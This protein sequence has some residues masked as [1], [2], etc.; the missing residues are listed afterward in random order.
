MSISHVASLKVRYLDRLGPEVSPGR[1]SRLSALAIDPK[2]GR[3]F[4]SDRHYNRVYICSLDGIVLGKFGS[5][6]SNDEQFHYGSL[7][8]DPTNG[9]I[10]VS[11][12]GH[13]QILIFSPDGSF[14]YTFGSAGSADGQFYWPHALAIDPQAQT[15]FV[16]DRHCYIQS[17]NTDGSFR[18]RIG[19]PS[20]CSFITGNSSN[21]D[22]FHLRRSLAI[23]LEN[24]NLII[25]DFDLDEIQIFKTDGTFV[26]KF[27][28]S[29]PDDDQIIGVFELA[30]NPISKK[31]FLSYAHRRMEPRIQIFNTDGVFLGKITLCAS[32]LAVNSEN[33][34]LYVTESSRQIQIF[35]K[36]GVFIRTFKLRAAA[37]Y[38]SCPTGMAIEPESGNIFVADFEDDCIRILKPDGSALGKFGLE[39]SDGQFKG[40]A[41][42]TIDSKSGNLFVVDTKHHQIQIFTM[43]GNYLRQFGSEGSGDCQFLCPADLEVDSKGYIFVSDSDNHCLQIIAPD[44]AFVGRIGSRGQGDGQFDSPLGLAIDPIS[45]NLFV[46]DSRNHRV[47]I[48]DSERTFVSKFG[49]KGVDNGQFNQPTGLVFDPKSRK[50]FVAD[51]LNCR[52]QIFSPDGT[53]CGKFSSEVQRDLPVF[54]A[55]DPQRRKLFAADMEHNQISVF[56][57]EFPGT[58]DPRMIDVFNRYGITSDLQD[59]MFDEMNLSVDL[60]PHLAVDSFVRLGFSSSDAIKLLVDLLTFQY[61]SAPNNRVFIECASNPQL[62]IAHSIPHAQRFRY[63]D[64]GYHHTCLTRTAC[65]HLSSSVT[66]CNFKLCRHHLYRCDLPDC[67]RCILPVNLRSE[68]LILLPSPE[69]QSMD[70]FLSSENVGLVVQ[71]TLIPDTLKLSS[72]FGGCQFHHSVSFLSVYLTDGFPSTVQL[73]T[74]IVRLQSIKDSGRNT[75]LLDDVDHGRLSVILLYCWFGCAYNI[76]PLDI[77]IL[78]RS[79]SNSFSHQLTDFDLSCVKSFLEENQYLISPTGI[80]KL[81]RNSSSA[82]LLAEQNADICLQLAIYHHRLK[83]LPDSEMEFIRNQYHLRVDAWMSVQVIVE[84]IF[85]QVQLTKNQQK[86]DETYA[87]HQCQ[88]LQIALLKP[89]LIPSHAAKLHLLQFSDH[90]L[91]DPISKLDV[92]KLLFVYFALLTSCHDCAKPEIWAAMHQQ[93]VRLLKPFGS[94]GDVDTS[95]SI[96][97]FVP[98]YFGTCDIRDRRGIIVERFARSFDTRNPLPVIVKE[99]L[100]GRAQSLYY[101][102][103]WINEIELNL[104]VACGY[105]PHIARFLGFDLIPPYNGY[106]SAQQAPWK[107]RLRFE[108]AKGG[109]LENWIGK[110][111]NWISQS[112]Q[113]AQSSSVEIAPISPLS[114]RV[115]LLKDIAHGLKVLH[116]LGVVHRDVKDAN[117]LLTD[118]EPPRAKLCDF[119]LSRELQFTLGNPTLKIGPYGLIAP[120]LYDGQPERSHLSKI[121]VWNFGQLAANLCSLGVSSVVPASRCNQFNSRL[122]IEPDHAYDHQITYSDGEVILSLK[123]ETDFRL[124]ITESVKRNPVVRPTMDQVHQ[125]LGAMFSDIFHHFE[126]I[127]II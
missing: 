22:H 7:A 80:R 121:D 92:A 115:R 45:G 74:L 41:G 6:G 46:V 116:Q 85:S 47:Q 111:K 2:N 72:C 53:F 13:H 97:E 35:D 82:L 26:R 39:T 70:H 93:I 98:V 79:L 90:P 66:N 40:P 88:L 89:S 109:S 76:D 73:N 105:H 32:G 8:V 14:L 61:S 60:L 58:R 64:C 102:C 118:D 108:Y 56:H 94:L 78:A 15:L 28:L 83:A 112:R 16:S 42:L 10:F 27:V 1:Q 52:I 101:L 55:V 124:L 59:I 3:L 36:D 123:Q 127:Q 4:V 24:G 99:V 75:V 103:L 86:L 113:A 120:E 91:I 77:E 65:L 68:S 104:R 63:C 31:I 95:E 100:L 43:D 19:P 114:H 30:F 38:F 5:P 29:G 12:S 50:L 84:D 81:M 20:G 54:L 11:D 21:D 57:L 18:G 87:E 67:P 107:L 17:F 125:R 96:S 51:T 49:S 106:A 119:D 23:D 33:G 37:D 71:F 48:F 44:G 110:Q 117:I 62:A 9:N 25:A 69:F 34:D 126:D 122:M